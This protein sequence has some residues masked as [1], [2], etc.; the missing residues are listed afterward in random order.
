MR[1]LALAPADST[2]DNIP[3]FEG[4]IDHHG[5]HIDHIMGETVNPIVDTLVVIFNMV[6]ATSHLGDTVV[7][8]LVGV[9]RSFEEGVLEQ[10]HGST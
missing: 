7:D 2:G 6:F 8:S 3:R 9:Y 5:E 1:I 4:A 10:K